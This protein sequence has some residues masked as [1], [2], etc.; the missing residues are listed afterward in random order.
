[1]GMSTRRWRPVAAANRGS[2]VERDGTEKRIA[3][4]MLFVIHGERSRRQPSSDPAREG[5]FCSRASNRRPRIRVPIGFVM[6]AQS[7]AATPAAPM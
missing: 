2:E 7:S 4:S 3:G 6:E 1:V 5:D